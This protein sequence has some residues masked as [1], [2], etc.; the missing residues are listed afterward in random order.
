MPLSPSLSQNQLSPNFVLLYYFAGNSQN[1]QVKNQQVT[2][3]IARSTTSID[4]T[5][6]NSKAPFMSPAAHRVEGIE[7]D[8]DAKE[9]AQQKDQDIRQND[10]DEQHGTRIMGHQKQE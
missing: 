6:G 9:E 2:R 1:S 3:E 7:E 5:G 4:S 10:G 8:A